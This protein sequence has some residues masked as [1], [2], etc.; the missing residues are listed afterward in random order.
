MLFILA[1]IPVDPGVFG[2]WLITHGFGWIL[3]LIGHIN[4]V[5]PCG[6]I[7]G[8]VSICGG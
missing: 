6:L 2:L 3:A 4:G 5:N 1:A 8:V 7:P